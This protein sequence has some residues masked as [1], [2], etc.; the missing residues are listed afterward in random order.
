MTQGV[1]M[2][3]LFHFVTLAQAGVY[4]HLDS[5][6]RRNDGED[7][8]DGDDGSDSEDPN[9]GEDRNDGDDGVVCLRG[10]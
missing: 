10:L 1:G 8:N 6:L 5:C 7:P 4:N 2:T 9:D 3:V